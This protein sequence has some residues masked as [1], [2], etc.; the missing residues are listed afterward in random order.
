MEV[1]VWLACFLVFVFIQLVLTYHFFQRTHTYWLQHQAQRFLFDHDT[2]QLFEHSSWLPV[3]LRFPY[4]GWLGWAIARFAVL[5]VVSMAVAA[6]GRRWTFWTPA[7]LWAVLPAFFGLG[8]DWGSRSLLTVGLPWT[9]FG[10]LMWLGVATDLA[11]VIAPATI[12]ALRRRPAIREPVC[13]LQVACVALCLVVFVLWQTTSASING[14]AAITWTFDLARLLPLFVLGALLGPS[15]RTFWVLA[16]CTA[17]YWL[18]W[19]ANVSFS[20]ELSAPIPVLIASIIP[21]ACAALL[22]SSWQPLAAGVRRVERRP[23]ALLAIANLLNVA[24]AV[25]TWLFV[26]SGQVVEANPIVRSIGLPSKVILVGIVTWLL[27]RTRPRALIW[28]TLVLLA[29]MAW[30]VAGIVLSR[31][32]PGG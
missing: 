16:A 18:W 22:G 4:A 2:R 28:P 25:A 13:G 19:R 5:T 8:P 31:M 12:V 14:Q 27:Y 9:S 3:W 20:P 1:S 17:L 29:V 32:L 21:F 15:L 10:L 23:A 30:D 26:R 11:L 6:K 24:D 7:I